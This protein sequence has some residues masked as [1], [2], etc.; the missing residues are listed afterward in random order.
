MRKRVLFLCTGNSCRSQMAEGWLRHVAGDRFE[1]LSA[2]ARPSG[3]V[4]PLAIRAMAEVGVDISRQRSKSITEFAGQPLDVV[5]TVC[6][7]ARESC[8]VLPGAKQTVHWSFDDP[9]EATGSEEQRM[10]VFRRVREEIRR[11][12]EQWV[13]NQGREVQ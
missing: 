12:V 7:H 3:F 8:P 5:I 11:C 1:A 6:D 13:Q 2:G 10:A 9:A 4:H